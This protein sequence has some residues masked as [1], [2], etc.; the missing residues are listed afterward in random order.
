[1]LFIFLTPELLE[2]CGSLRQLSPCIGVYYTLFHCN[3]HSTLQLQSVNLAKKF[4]MTFS[5][6]SKF[7]EFN[8]P[9]STKDM[10]WTDGP[11]RDLIK[12]TKSFP[13]WTILTK[14][15]GHN[16]SFF[17]SKLER[18]SLA[19]TSSLKCNQWPVL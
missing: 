6:N 8:P 3:D 18:L 13:K 10:K 17:S 12:A 15:N 7:D 11:K 2:I 1:M 5:I 19:D 14:K 4:F 16:F 9:P